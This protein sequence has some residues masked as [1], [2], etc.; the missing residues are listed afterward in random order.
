MHQGAINPLSLI[1]ESW[2]SRMFFTGRINGRFV[3]Y[4]AVFDIIT[5]RHVGMLQEMAL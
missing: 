2:N 1:K 4:N 3:G 5:I